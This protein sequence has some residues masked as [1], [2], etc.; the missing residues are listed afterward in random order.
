MNIK[1]VVWRRVRFDLD[2][3]FLSIDNQGNH[4]FVPSKAGATRLTFTQAR[5]QAKTKT[6]EARENSTNQYVYGYEGEY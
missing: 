2:I 4:W 5:H 6:K 1:Y 3:E